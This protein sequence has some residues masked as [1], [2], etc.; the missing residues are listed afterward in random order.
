MSPTPPTATKQSS[1]SSPR[2]T[3]RL[4]ALSIAWATAALVTAAA[5][6]QVTLQVFASSTETSPYAS[7]R[8]G[9]LALHTAIERA[10]SAAAGTDGEDAALSRFRSA[11]E[12]EWRYRDGIAEACKSSTDAQGDLD[13]IE[14]L[15][16]AEEH[17]IRREA[18]SLAPLR[19]RV[20]SI[21][22]REFPKTPAP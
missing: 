9:L 8:E 21:F 11:L 22:D 5:S 1:K 6:I 19:R 20:K 17:A 2:K 7:C 3:G 4:V 16:Y 18:G 15:R 10:R 13:A 12:P 14:R